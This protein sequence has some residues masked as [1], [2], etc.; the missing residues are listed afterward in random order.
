MKC[1]RLL[2]LAVLLLPA[3]CAGQADLVQ[4]RGVSGQ[5]T[6]LY[7]GEITVMSVEDMPASMDIA[8]FN[9]PL[10]ASKREWYFPGG[11]AQ[12]SVNIFLLNLEDKMVLVDAGWGPDGAVKGRA[13][14]ELEN[15]GIT[16]DMIDVVLLTH[17]HGDHIA[18]LINQDDEPIFPNAEILA[19]KPEY[20]FWLAKS[21]LV[22]P[23]YKSWAEIAQKV[24]TAYRGRCFAFNFGKEVLPGVQA[25]GAPGHTP[26]HTAFLVTGSQNSLLIAGDF[27]HA[28]ALQFAHPDEYPSYD[29]DQPTAAKIRRALMEMAIEENLVIGGMHIQHPG[30]GVVKKSGR[31]YQFIPLPL[32]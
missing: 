24:A 28:T 18:G 19:S 13:L 5:V 20:D 21:T 17:M 29:M 23:S 26:G 9:G 14:E 10:R 2:L 6:E 22:D 27:V 25:V 3:A 11:K 16:P 12:G 32:E 15:V 31:G 1:F 30:L 7:L 8:L 4:Q